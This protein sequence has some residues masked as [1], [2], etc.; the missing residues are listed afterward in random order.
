[1]AGG[2][3]RVIEEQSDVRVVK[4]QNNLSCGAACGEMLLKEKGINAINQ[5]TIINEGSAPISPAY[6][7]SVLNN[8][9][10]SNL[11]E[12]RG[13]G[14]E[15]EGL[16][17]SEL[18]DCLI[19]TGVWVAELRELG[20]RLGHLVVVDGWDNQG[21]VLIRDPWQGTHYKMEPKEFINYW[22][23][24]GIFWVEL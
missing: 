17:F 19:S 15:I 11:G 8:L 5:D 16:G 10:P 12:W 7:A 18:L 14:L 6:L 22:T 13:G 23:L 9:S 2:N 3:W 20:T 24:R 21:R 4:Q 1:L